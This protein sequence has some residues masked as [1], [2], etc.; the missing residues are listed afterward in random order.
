MKLG[1]YARFGLLGLTAGLA[2]TI[3]LLHFD[4][5]EQTPP[6]RSSVK[7]P[8]RTATVQTRYT[9]DE[10]RLT[11]TERDWETPSPE[12]RSRVLEYIAIMRF[13]CGDQAGALE[14]MA[15]IR[16]V[17]SRD[18]ALEHLFRHVTATDPTSEYSLQ[19]APVPPPDNDHLPPG[20]ERPKRD[21]DSALQSVAESGAIIIALHEPGR[22]ALAFGRVGE[23]QAVELGDQKGALESFRRAVEEAE[24]IEPTRA[25]WLEG[26]VAWASTAWHYF[27][28]PTAIWVLGPIFTVVMVLVGAIVKPFGEEIAQGLGSDQVAGSISRKKDSAINGIKRAFGRRESAGGITANLVPPPNDGI[29]RPHPENK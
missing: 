22:R 12:N 23:I 18:Q 1:H 5:D 28:R 19:S 16:D 10:T 14:T 13:G 15:L 4:R 3:I 9:N 7:L 21:R 26:L 20:M 25:S 27:G 8:N 24:K 29:V 2:V 6:P 11:P 17:N